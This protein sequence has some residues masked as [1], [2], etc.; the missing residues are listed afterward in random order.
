MARPNGRNRLLPRMAIQ[1]VMAF[2]LVRTVRPGSAQQ[3]YDA[4]DTPRP[5]AEEEQTQ[6]QVRVEEI[7]RELVCNAL[8]ERLR[9]SLSR[10]RDVLNNLLTREVT[11]TRA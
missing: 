9:Q 8:T 1:W 5:S 11:T 2:V 7:D 6:W 10:E 4:S 3:S